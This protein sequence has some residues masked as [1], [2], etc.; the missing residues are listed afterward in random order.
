M[1]FFMSSFTSVLELG[2]KVDTYVSYFLYAACSWRVTHSVFHL[3][4]ISHVNNSSKPIIRSFY[5]AGFLNWIEQ[6]ILVLAGGLNWLFPMNPQH[7]CFWL[8]K[9]ST[10]RPPRWK[11]EFTLWKNTLHKASGCQNTTV[12]IQWTKYRKSCDN[13]GNLFMCSLQ[14]LTDSMASPPAAVSDHTIHLNY[15][16]GL[17]S[18]FP[19]TSTEQDTLNPCTR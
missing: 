12:F 5:K 19:S 13:L 17:L 1:A 9:N 18:L 14:M 6:N 7:Y 10:W 8:S 15:T 11:E 16:A 3:S 4:W 2:S